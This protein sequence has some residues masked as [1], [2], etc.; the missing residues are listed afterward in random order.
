M[1][2]KKDVIGK[3]TENVPPKTSSQGVVI[4]SNYLHHFGRKEKILKRNEVT[5]TSCFGA[6]KIALNTSPARCDIAD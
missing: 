1:G 5:F 2:D 3:T 6:H 4:K